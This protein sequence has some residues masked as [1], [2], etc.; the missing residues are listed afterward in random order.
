MSD[1]SDLA[2]LLNTHYGFSSF[3]P[4]QEEIVSSIC[5]GNDTL[6]LMP[7]GGG[8]SL[9]FQLPAL[10][11]TGTTLVISPLIAL[12]KDQVDALKVRGIAASFINSSLPADEIDRRT[13]AV[14]EGKVKLLYIAPERLA[15][16]FTEI[17]KKI[18][19][20]L[21]AIDEAHCVS[22]WGH[23]FR[24]DYLEIQKHVAQ[25]SKRPI[26]AAFTATATPE[27]KADIIK[28]LGLKNPQTFVRGFDRPN[29]RFFTRA[30]LSD[31]ER[32]EEVLR[33]ARSMK[34][35]GIVYCG[36][37]NKTEELARYLQEHGIKALP[38]HAGMN[39][40]DRVET[41]ERFMRDEARLITATI[42]FG[43]GVDKPDVRFVIHAH[44]PAS[45]ENYYQEAGRA[46]RDGETAHCV[47]LHSAQDSALHEFFIGKNYE[48]SLDRG[49]SLQE[50]TV[51]RVIKFEKL[52]KIKE[53]V[54]ARA[55]RRKIILD[56]FG[57]GSSLKQDNCK[58]CD[59]CLSYRWE[60]DGERTSSRDAA[61][62][63]F[64]SE[65]EEY[66][67]D[68]ALYDALRAKRKEVAS[69]LRIHAYMVFSDRILQSIAAQ[70]PL[71]REE[72][73]A[74]PG[75][76]EKLYEK[77]G[78]EFAGVVAAYVGENLDDNMRVRET[79]ESMSGRHGVS[80]TVA[81]SVFLHQ[82][83][84]TVPQIVKER[85]VSESTIHGHLAKWYLAGGEFDINAFLPRDKERAVLRAMSECDDPSRL[86]SIKE[87]CLDSITYD[88]IRWLIAKMKKV[89]L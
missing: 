21:V 6:A 34:G 45:L 57:D 4:G 89:K 71:N 39:A 66:D 56:Y 43:M 76:G 67:Y 53:Y 81:T 33:L 31:D 64:G 70:A 88:D 58:G 23:D 13:R 30:W 50:A 55:C 78:R 5:A 80:E 49:K 9:C 51:V 24:P 44:M 18:P 25:F 1:A 61:V 8:K 46:G 10:A 16:G 29:L 22:T 20:S 85:G 73:L 82:Q 62:I 48:E 3:R 60:G 32:D 2:A 19:V 47:L 52:K 65:E 63:S 69:R 54:T 68:E 84:K 72:W 28:R 15:T 37:R 38:Y 77:F 87:K 27:V 36:I 41:Q 42:A 83:G 86:G 59:Y 40:K 14:L 74:I 79:I 7:T 35:S 12:M 75:V 17:F 26:L 11:L